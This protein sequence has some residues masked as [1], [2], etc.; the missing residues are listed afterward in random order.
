M[1]GTP[2][3][4]RAARPGCGLAANLIPRKA[5]EER[6]AHP[7]ANRLRAAGMTEGCRGGSSI[8]RRREG[9]VRHVHVYRIQGRREGNPRERWRPELLSGW[10]LTGR[11]TKPGIRRNIA[12]TNGCSC[13]PR[14]TFQ[15]GT[16]P[17]SRASAWSKPTR[18]LPRFSSVMD[19]G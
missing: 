7:P 9:A 8:K 3:G 2:R 10:C 11:R 19:S 15:S 1:R 18:F 5:W 13:L 4:D 6:K 12:R 17:F 14:G 16:I